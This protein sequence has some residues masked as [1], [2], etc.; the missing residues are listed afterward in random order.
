[1]ARTQRSLINAYWVKEWVNLRLPWFRLRSSIRVHF[2]SA[3]PL[4]YLSWLA[5]NLFTYRVSDFSP[6]PCLAQPFWPWSLPLGCAMKSVCLGAV[7]LAASMISSSP[8]LLY[9]PKEQKQPKLLSWDSKR[10]LRTGSNY[11]I[12]T[13][14]EVDSVSNTV[15]SQYHSGLPRLLN[16]TSG[17]SFSSWVPS[18]KGERLKT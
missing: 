11:Q 3:S 18:F 13:R 16:Y 1:M 14:H 12:Y 9:L 7:S 2:A 4:C 10:E 15:V 8:Q 5:T 6:H 17:T